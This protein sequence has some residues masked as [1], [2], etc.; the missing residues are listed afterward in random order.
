M[1]A[2]DQTLQHFLDLT[3]TAILLGAD[4]CEGARPAATRIFT[5][6]RNKV[7]PRSGAEPESLPVCSILGE[8]LR[9][10]GKA[11]APIPE[12]ATTLAK[13]TPALAWQRRKGAELESPGFFDGHANA[14][15][16]G[17]VG[18]EIR[19]DVWIGIS[20]MAPHVRYPN[21]RHPPEEIYVSLAGGDWKKEQHWHRP[22]PGDLIYNEPNVLH[23]MATDEEP[24]LA[25]WCLWVGDEQDSGQAGKI[26]S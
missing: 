12:L 17:P 3:E 7:G 19:N 18:V 9:I 10:S 5:A 26:T 14:Y 4:S 20:L 2:R 24:L 13:L 15:V 1:T 8:A 22:K 6:L 25:I 21:H 11:V 16:V 23:A